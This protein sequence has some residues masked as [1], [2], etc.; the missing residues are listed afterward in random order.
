MAANHWS[1]VNQ[2]LSRRRALASAGGVA[3]GAALLAACGSG[4]SSTSQKQPKNDLVAEP[5]D[6]L[7]QAKRGGNL[8]LVMYQDVQGFDPGFANV[9]NEAIKIYPY[10]WLMAYEAGFK[11]PSLNK[12]IPDIGESWEF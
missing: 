7:K 2:R 10:S 4:G 8:K 1:G 5:V 6:N 12:V 3:L 9:P 11:G